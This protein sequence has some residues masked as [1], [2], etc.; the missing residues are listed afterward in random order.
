MIQPTSSTNKKV[1]ALRAMI[2][3]RRYTSS[4]FAVTSR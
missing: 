4:I 1:G 2:R 3:S